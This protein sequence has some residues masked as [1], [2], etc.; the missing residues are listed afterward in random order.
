MTEVAR[1]LDIAPVTSPISF[2][3]VNICSNSSIV[4]RCSFVKCLYHILC[5]FYVY[6]SINKLSS[7][8]ALLFGV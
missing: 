3:L 7:F 6:D 8:K 5:R 1:Q 2:R 4:Y